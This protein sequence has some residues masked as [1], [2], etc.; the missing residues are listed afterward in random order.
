MVSETRATPPVWYVG[1]YLADGRG[2]SQQEAE[3]AAA[4]FGWPGPVEGLGDGFGAVLS[5]EDETLL[6]AQGE[7]K[8]MTL[9]GKVT[10]V[11]DA[12]EMN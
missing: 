9:D 7:L 2:A 1:F 6:M 8:R 3:A 10:V 12:G 11:I 4:E 5:Y